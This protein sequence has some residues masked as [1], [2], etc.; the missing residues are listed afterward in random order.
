MEERPALRWAGLLFHFTNMKPAFRKLGKD[1]QLTV[2]LSIPL[3]SQL[4][5]SKLHS[6]LSTQQGLGELADEDRYK[7]CL[8]RCTVSWVSEHTHAIEKK[9]QAPYRG[10]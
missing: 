9:T 8:L 2:N 1:L 5:L 6:A 3:L 7:P 10:R 4:S